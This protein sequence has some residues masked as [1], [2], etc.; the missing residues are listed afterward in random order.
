ML[1]NLF[2]REVPKRPSIL[3]FV[4]STRGSQT[5]LF[6]IFALALALDFK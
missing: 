4:F 2:G 6:F 5:V 3:L 1:T